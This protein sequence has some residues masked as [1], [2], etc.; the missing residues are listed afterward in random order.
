MKNRY[1]AAPVVSRLVTPGRFVVQI[2]YNMVDVIAVYH[3]K[4]EDVRSTAS[5]QIPPF[6]R[7]SMM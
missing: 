7:S 4:P 6:L 1:E 5:V 2:R 3:P